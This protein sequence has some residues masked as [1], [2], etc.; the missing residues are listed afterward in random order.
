MSKHISV[1]T[2]ASRGIG[3]AIALRLAEEGHNLVIIARNK[4][5]LNETKNELEN[6]GA[7]VLTFAGDV[8]DE[9]FVNHTVDKIY[10]KFGKVDHMI[11]NAGVSVFDKLIDSKLEDFKRQIDTNIIGVYNFSKAVAAK[12]IEAKS[13]SIINIAS[14]AGKNGFSGGTMYSA[15]KHAVLGF[16]KSLMQELREYDIR[17]AAVCPG[18]V[19]TEFLMNS[20]RKPDKPEK[21]LSPGD[22][23][24]VV[25]TIIKLPPRALVNDIEIRP[26]NPK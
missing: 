10:D 19:A 25:S 24:E 26:T 16:S 13:G 20:S 11:N 17:V 15:T 23:A 6:K 22:V 14:L 18:S 7:E 9:N 1:I 3:K 5:K 2:G 4:E 21:L 12:F 8:A